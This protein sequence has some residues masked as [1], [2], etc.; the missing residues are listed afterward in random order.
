[1]N[2]S[3][4]PR[5]LRVF[6]VDDALAIRARI[7]A[8]FGAIDGVEIA[9]EA[10]EPEAAF[11]AIAASGADLVVLDLRLAGG[12]AMDLL[13]RLARHAPPP[14]TM[15]LTNHSGVW[16]RE[17]CLAN[18]ARYFFDKTGEF[19]LACH[20]IKQLVHAHGARGLHHLGAHHV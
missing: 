11:A 7:A 8:R 13:Q 6:L 15:V 3:P 4:S 12:T 2:S 16:F 20:A 10:E 19:E 9:G 14:V 5:A 18:G 17:A 1:M